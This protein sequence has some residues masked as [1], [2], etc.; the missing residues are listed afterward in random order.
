[1]R[2][3]VRD[4]ALERVPAVSAE[5]LEAREL[6]LD[7]NAGRARRV[8]GRLAVRRDRDGG[9]LGGRPVRG[10]RRLGLRPEPRRVGIQSQ[11]QLG[12]ALRDEGVQPVGEV[13]TGRRPAVLRVAGPQR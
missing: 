4:D 9:A 8:D 13:Q 12:L 11:D 3:R 7:R 1:V 2:V 10:R 5:A 6:R